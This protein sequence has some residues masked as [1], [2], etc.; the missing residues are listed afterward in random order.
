[1]NDFIEAAIERFNISQQEKDNIK[2][3][4]KEFLDAYAIKT[5]S[6]SGL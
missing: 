2:K 1:M 4:K 6:D 3:N 5:P